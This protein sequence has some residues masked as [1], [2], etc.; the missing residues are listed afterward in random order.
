[1]YTTHC[2][3]NDAALPVSERVAA[4]VVCADPED[5]SFFGQSVYPAG[6]GLTSC[7]GD[8]DRLLRL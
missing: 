1:M 7:S 3:G 6:I 2:P 8:K 5:M 4:A